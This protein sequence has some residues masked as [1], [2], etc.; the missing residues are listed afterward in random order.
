MPK[1][2]IPIHN[3]T[4][5]FPFSYLCYHFFFYFKSKLFLDQFSELFQRVLLLAFRYK[6]PVLKKRGG[7]VKIYEIIPF[8]NIFF[9]FLVHRSYEATY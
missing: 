6:N 7:G 8:F 9:I 4:T 2:V 1:Q 3:S 5:P